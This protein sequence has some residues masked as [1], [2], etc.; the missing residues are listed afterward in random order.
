MP[1][2]P[3]SADAGAGADEPGAAATARRRGRR[4]AGEDTRGA[5][6]A[7][8][9]EEF[10]DR[11]F[12]GASIRSV[13][14]RADVDPGLVRHY[15]RTKSDLFAAGIVPTGIDPAVLAAGLAA[16]GVDGLGAR[17]LTTVLGIWGRDGGVALRV[18]FA[19]MT[20]GETQAEALAGY[21]GREVFGR[22]AQLLPPPD[23]QL[24]VSLVASQVAGVLL[25]R[26]VLR[27][28][29]LASMPVDDVVA[30]VAPTLDRYLTGSLGTT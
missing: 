7:A 19:G 14:R 4:P 18:A 25:A 22:V 16:G 2:T 9:R 13:A 6:L 5:I 1:P 17:L 29:P 30:L 3:T 10:A 26:H 24:R 28:E 11:G 23:Q 8:A 12:D 20:A 15:F 21:V 27:L